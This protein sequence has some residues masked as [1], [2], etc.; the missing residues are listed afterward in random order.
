MRPAAAGSST[1][2]GRWSVATAYGSSAPRPSARAGRRRVK[3]VELAEE[4]VDHRVADEVDPVLGDALAHE[5]RDRLRARRE[6]EVGQGIGDDPVDLLGHGPVVA[7]QP[8]LDVGEG[9]AGLR[10]HERRGERRVDVTVDHDQRRIELGEGRLEGDEQRRRLAGV[11]ARSDA[12]IE[13]RLG[14]GEVAEEDVG[15][16]RVVVLSGVDEPLVDLATPERSDHGR[17]LHEVRPGA[18]HVDDGGMHRGNDT[19]FPV[20]TYA[21]S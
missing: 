4:G 21:G 17:G 16:P 7:P 12:E 10:R 13:V 14:Q 11:R 1:L 9:T 20:L 5:L 18:H 2:A 3:A 6:Q 15:Q 8:C 19:G